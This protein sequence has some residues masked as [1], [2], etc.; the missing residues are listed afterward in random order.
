MVLSSLQGH[1]SPISVWPMWATAAVEKAVFISWPDGI[2]DNLNQA[3][4]LLGLVLHY[5]SRTFSLI[6][7]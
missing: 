7:V 1:H 3:L 2:K 4:V 5:I 6:V